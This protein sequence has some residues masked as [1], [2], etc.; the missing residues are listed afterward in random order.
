MA[1]PQA[2]GLASHWEGGGWFGT[3]LGGT[4]WLFV[5]ALV[6]ESRSPSSAAFVAGCGLAANLVGC[7]LWMNRSRLDPY[8]AQ[9]I[10]VAA[11][12]AAG[13][14]ATRWL[15]RRGEFGLVDSRVSPQLMYFLLAVLGAVL[16]A[17]IEVKGRAA[18]SAV[19]GPPAPPNP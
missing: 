18:R 16:L 17:S 13:V 9:Q 15:E 12:V 3:Q 14:V 5:S 10:L 6:V 8:R 7:L 19:A 4:A 11:I 1:T 2:H